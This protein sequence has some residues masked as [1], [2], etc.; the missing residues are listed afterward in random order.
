MK[1]Y[2]AATTQTTIQVNQQL[3][4]DLLNISLRK[5]SLLVSA[6]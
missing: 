3:E 4:E 2:S 5:E 1:Q 6:R